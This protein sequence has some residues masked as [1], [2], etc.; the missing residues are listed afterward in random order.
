MDFIHF[1][2]ISSNGKAHVFH[3]CVYY[4]KCSKKLH[5]AN[6][7]KKNGRKWERLAH[8]R[9]QQMVIDKKKSYVW[10]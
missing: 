6:V 8:K 4:G 1:F 3:V 7:T 5:I 9:G 10:N 2:I